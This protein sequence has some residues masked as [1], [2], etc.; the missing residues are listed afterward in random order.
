[1]RGAVQPGSARVIN[2]AE[3]RPKRVQKG[4]VRATP[5]AREFSSRPAADLPQV[6]PRLEAGRYQKILTR[7]RAGHT[8]AADLRRA[9]VHRGEARVD[10]A[11]INRFAN[12]RAAL[13]RQGIPVV[14]A[15]DSPAGESAQPTVPLSGDDA[16]KSR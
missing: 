13:E 2:V 5:A 9:P 11:E 14:S 16:A 7:Y 12:P 1:M 8:R 4:T 10:L 15:G 3:T 6:V